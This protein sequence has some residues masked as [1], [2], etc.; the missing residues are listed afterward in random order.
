MTD[1]LTKHEKNLGAIMHASTFGRYLIP[2]GN[3]IFPLI[4]WLANKDEKPFIDYNGKK[5]LNFQLSIF[6]YSVAVL[7]I[8]IPLFIGFTPKLFQN[9][10]FNI[11]EYINFHD[12]NF[13][14]IN[15]HISTDMFFPGFK[16][17]PLGLT[18][19]LIGALNIMNIIYS[20]LGTIK[21]NEG[22]YFKYPFTINFIK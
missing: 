5:V 22:Q 17:W 4:L 16:L 11:W 12:S 14:D 9:G 1:T 15:F 6:I 21:T 3:F 10:L 18:G 7:A 8:G 19:L 2:F 13:D 20:I